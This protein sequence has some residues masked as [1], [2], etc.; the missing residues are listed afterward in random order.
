MSR[1]PLSEACSAFDL[2]VFHDWFQ[3]ESYWLKV[4]ISPIP[5]DLMNES[6]HYWMLVC[7]QSGANSLALLMSI[8]C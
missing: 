8:S 5:W 3:N 6:P 1:R 2:L 7:D 4:M